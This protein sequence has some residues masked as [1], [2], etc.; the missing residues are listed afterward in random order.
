MGKDI[1]QSQ[2]AGNDDFKSR[3]G[4][5]IITRIH[6]PLFIGIRIENSIVTRRGNNSIILRSHTSRTINLDLRSVPSSSMLNSSYMVA[7]KPTNKNNKM[8]QKYK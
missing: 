7:S 1:K 2:N 6:Y 4:K 8:S 5:L 3:L